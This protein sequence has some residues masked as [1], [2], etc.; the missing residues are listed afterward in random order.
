MPGRKNHSLTYW[1]LFIVQA[2]N[3]ESISMSSWGLMYS[4]RHSLQNNWIRWSLPQPHI[5]LPS[6]S[7]F[8]FLLMEITIL[9]VITTH[10]H[11]FLEKNHFFY[12]LGNILYLKMW[13]A[14]ERRELSHYSDLAFEIFNLK[15]FPF[16][17]NLR[18]HRKSSHFGGMVVYFQAGMV[19][20]SVED[21][22]GPETQIFP[23]Y[24]KGIWG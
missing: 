17:F 8:P 11:F 22:G 12:S 20:Q 14:E 7:A 4:D 6:S 2:F 15:Y 10:L 18:R 21:T 1:E 23:F 9:T 24:W 13:F 16:H 3:L 5:F 19:W